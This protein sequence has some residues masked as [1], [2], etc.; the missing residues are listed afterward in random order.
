MDL[1]ERVTAAIPELRDYWPEIKNLFSFR[2]IPEKTTLLEEGDV[3]KYLYIVSKGCLRLFVIKEDGREVTAQFFFENQMVASME[4][5]FTGKPGRMY[6]ESIEESE[7]V[8]IRINDFRKISERFSE[9][10][11]FMVNFL[12]QRLL[13][14]TDLYTSFILNTPEERYEKLLKDNP[15]MIERV[16]HH[17]IASYLGITAVSLS[18]I[19]SRIA[20]KD[21]R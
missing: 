16:P 19:R 14:Y 4:S 18:R 3:S 1:K 8:V 2:R 17:Y 6:L 9:M 10:N 20:K 13:Y 11:K 15:E 7:V 21:P 5:A 12:Q